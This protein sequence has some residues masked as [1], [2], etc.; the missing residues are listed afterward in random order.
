M[1]VLTTAEMKELG[2]GRCIYSDQ[3]VEDLFMCRR[4]APSEKDGHTGDR[5]RG[6]LS[7]SDIRAAGIKRSYPLVM[8]EDW[9][10]EFSINT[11][12]E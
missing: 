9:C 5:I 3:V 2:C 11:D 10:G 1:K 4:H 12:E 6:L 8:S 7:S